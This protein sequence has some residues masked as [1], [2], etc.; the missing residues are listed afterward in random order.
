[1]LTTIQSQVAKLLSANRRQ[2]N[3]FAGGAVLNRRTWHLSDDLDISRRGLARQG[4]IALDI[5]LGFAP[6]RPDNQI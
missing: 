2:G 5:R 3:Y 4:V 1:M 6:F